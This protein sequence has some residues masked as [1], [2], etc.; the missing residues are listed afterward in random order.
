MP[1]NR[2]LLLKVADAIENDPDHWDQGAWALPTPEFAREHPDERL[3]PGAV[4]GCGA[5][6]CLAGWGI[7]LENDPALR[8]E[9]PAMT[10][11]TIRLFRQDDRMG[12]RWADWKAEGA[13]AFGFTGEEAAILFYEDWPGVDMDDPADA[14]R[15]IRDVA[16]GA[17][18]VELAVEYLHW[19]RW[20]DITGDDEADFS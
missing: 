6:M 16:D 11:S 2:E 14:A 9:I 12:W 19:S 13:R 5:T 18:V 17:D 7:A 3:E 20:D 1:R 4:S 10:S 15:F 8:V